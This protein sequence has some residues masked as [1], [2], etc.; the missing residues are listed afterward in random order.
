MRE[1]TRMRIMAIACLTCA[2][3]NKQRQKHAC[4]RGNQMER[5]VHPRSSRFS[6]ETLPDRPREIPSV[7]C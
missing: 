3:T 6:P 5:C 7:D 1:I 4:N 2:R